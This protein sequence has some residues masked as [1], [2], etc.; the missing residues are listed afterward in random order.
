MRNYFSE[1]LV[2]REVSSNNS[3]VLFQNVNGGPR[4]TELSVSNRWCEGKGCHKRAPTVTLI[5]VGKKCLTLIG[6]IGQL[7]LKVLYRTVFVGT[8]LYSNK[9]NVCILRICFISLTK[10]LLFMIFHNRFNGCFS[11]IFILL[12]DYTEINFMEFNSYLRRSL[13]WQKHL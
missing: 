13:P 2:L 1:L 6:L 5:W 10:Y 8:A 7:S 3:F 12:K 9:C 4:H 11:F